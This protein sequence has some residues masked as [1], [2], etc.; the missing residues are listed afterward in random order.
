MHDNDGVA[1]DGGL[2]PANR[3]TALVTA[4]LF[5]IGHHVIVDNTREIKLYA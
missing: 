5:D 3:L 2:T 1:Q 4:Y